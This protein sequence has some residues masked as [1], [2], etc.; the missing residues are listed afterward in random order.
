MTG[1]TVHQATLALK[2]TGLVPDGGNHV[3]Q[4]LLDQVE[5]RRAIRSFVLDVYGD[6]G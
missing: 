2:T 6:R 1:F 4:V 3:R 5:A